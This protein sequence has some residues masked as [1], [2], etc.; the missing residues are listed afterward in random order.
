[1]SRSARSLPGRFVLF[2]ME[3]NFLAEGYSK[4]S[5]NPAPVGILAN[6]LSSHLVP[7]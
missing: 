7:G 6:A 4:K 1:V 3:R 2:T 5:I